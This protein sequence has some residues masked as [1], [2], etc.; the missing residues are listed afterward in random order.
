M[1]FAAAQSSMALTQPQKE[2]P[3]QPLRTMADRVGKEVE[4][5]AERVDHWHTHGNDDAKAKYQTTLRMVGKFKD[6][7]EATVKDL[8]KQSDADNK[9]DLDQSVRRRIQTMA[10]AA[11]REKGGDDD[12]V[13]QSV[14]PSVESSNAI[15]NSSD[16]QELRQWQ[17]EVATWKLLSL[18]IEHNYP[19]PGTDPKVVKQERL[20]GLE[21]THRYSPNSEIWDRF[22]LEDDQAKEKQLILKWLEQTA[23]DSE[24]DIGSITAQLEAESGK[25][26]N[27][28]TSGWLDTKSKVKQ[29]K[30]S[31]ISDQLL[32]KDTPLRNSEGLPLLTRLDPDAP[33]RDSRKLE[34]SDEYYERALWM[35]LY[36]MVRRG[37]PWSE[38]CEWCRDRNEAWRGV[39]IGA[40]YESHPEGAPNLSGPTVGYL[41]RRMCLYASRGAPSP[42]EAAVYGLLCGDLKEVEPVCR[43]WDDHLY[44]RFNALLLSR[45]DEYLLKNHS[46]KVPPTLGNKFTFKSALTD[47]GSWESSTTRV[48]Q[49][50]GQQKATASQSLSPMK[51]IQGH[52]ISNAVE[53]LVFHVGAA[54]TVMLK[55]DKRPTTLLMIPET[56]KNLFFVKHFAALANDPHAFRTLVHVFIVFRKGLRL[57][58]EDGTDRWDIM[59]NTIATYIEFLRVTKRISL[60]PLYAAQLSEGR[61][62]HCLARVL[63]DINNPEERE[64]MIGLMRQYRIDES[65]VISQNVVL[66]INRI[67]KRYADKRISRYT[68][69]RPMDHYLWPGQCIMRD[70]PGL[71]ISTEEESL[72]ESLRWYLHLE[73]DM[74]DT[75]EY[76]TTAMKNLLVNG[77]VGAAIQICDNLSLETVSQIK[78]QAFCGYAFNFMEPGSEEQDPDITRAVGKNASSSGR[79]SIRPSEIPTREQHRDIVID[80]RAISRTYYALHQIVR[81]IVLFR[82]WRDE[83]AK[84]MEL[85]TSGDGKVNTKQAKDIF[86]QIQATM[87]TL[88]LEDLFANPSVNTDPKFI[89]I[90]A[91]YLPE[92]LIAYLSTIQAAA[93]FTSREFVVKAMDVATVV[94]DADQYWL[95]DV[96]MKTGRM[97]ELV[98]TLALVSRA[99]LTLGEHEDS[100]KKK[101]VTKKRGNR[102]ETLKL[103]DLNVRN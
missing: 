9:G 51:L 1:S 91:A 17:A 46:N 95:Q 73:K 57:F 48:I 47:V 56:A 83:E 72:I 53:E 28:W 68:I 52:I 41:F 26:T 88:L 33:V 96:L 62:I 66:T 24:S 70:F 22:L 87:D 102:G 37:V 58:E 69:L 45:F 11:S 6:L 84:L 31:Q 64:R 63:P 25:G 59:D 32:P 89:A 23:K 43:G 92:L 14:L 10:T 67:R 100:K 101:T 7:A 30:R 79:A 38:I 34:R 78:T 60:I 97:S 3:L 19:E 49:L 20:E 2:D 4:K 81:A 75:F 12:G 5:F 94:A 76:L 93:F 8:K 77:R 90:Q 86:G 65:L 50:L 44:A 61:A 21:A 13:F 82:E 16:V 54:F 85:R 36:E 18:I 15:A 39:S 103:W 55:Q 98:E 27:T 40:A 71:D 99:M 80:L 42:Y 35:V 29:A 74:V